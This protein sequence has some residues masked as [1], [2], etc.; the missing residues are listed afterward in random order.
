MLTNFL[1]MFVIKMLDDEDK[2]K[3][4]TDLRSSDGGKIRYGNSRFDLWSGYLQPAQLLVRLATGQK[5]TQ[6]GEIIKANRGR[7]IEDFGRSKANPIVG[8]IIDAYTGRTFYGG[9]FGG[10][11]KGRPGE[12]MTKYNV[13]SWLQGVSKEVWN[14]MVPLVIQDAADALADAG[15]PMAVTAGMFSFFG[16]GTQTYPMWSS[17]QLKIEQNKMAHKY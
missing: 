7:I 3:I 6:A 1:V 13:P 12:V 17:T 9:R 14:R 5:K 11:P 16:G 2:F 8:L 15:I 4:E 10:P